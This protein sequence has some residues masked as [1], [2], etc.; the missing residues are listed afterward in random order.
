[1]CFVALIY[2]FLESSTH[3]YGLPK[4]WEEYCLSKSKFALFYNKKIK[5][6]TYDLDIFNEISIIL[7]FALFL[8]SVIVCIIDFCTGFL[9]S[10]FLGKKWILVISVSVP[11]LPFIY[12][13]ILAYIWG[14]F[15]EK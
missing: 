6:K 8:I 14:V 9:V 15:D 1:M 11:A 2:V 4:K 5:R 3:I 7:H 13:F 12:Y 10:V